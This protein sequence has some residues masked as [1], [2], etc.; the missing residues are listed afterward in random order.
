MKK[1]IFTPIGVIKSD[2]KKV[3]DA[4]ICCEKGLKTT[5]TSKII[6]DDRFKKGLKGIENFSHIFVIY[7]LHEVN[8]S[9]LVT[10]PG[11]KSIEKLP[12]V[13]LFASR[14]QYRP[15]PIALRLAKLLEVKNF[16]LTVQGLDG[17]NNSPVL[18]G[19][20]LLP[21]LTVDDDIP[22]LSEEYYGIEFI[23]GFELGFKAAKEKY[24]WT[25]E[26]VINIIEK[27]RETEFTAE[28]LVSSLTQP[29]YPVAF[30]AASSDNSTPN[31][32]SNHFGSLTWIGTWV[33]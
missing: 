2:F 10:Y 31:L 15:N 32:R 18:E 1:I 4:E 8:K 3:K 20:D 7:F 29:K 14:S 9:E 27:S 17:I 5:T 13:G 28:Y 16:E 33:Y 25:Y 12:K 11:P 26:D 22:K 23:D 6:I 24:K 21:A 19:T 30:N